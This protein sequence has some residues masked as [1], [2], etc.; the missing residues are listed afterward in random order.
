M[1]SHIFL[2]LWIIGYFAN[3]L[4]WTLNWRHHRFG[5]K[6][7]GHIASLLLWPLLLPMGAVSIIIPRV[8]RFYK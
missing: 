3:A 8:N 2:T 5:L 6:T 7:S 1:D 4:A